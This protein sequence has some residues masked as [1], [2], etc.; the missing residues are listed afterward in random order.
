[1]KKFSKE[2]YD[3][4]SMALGNH[5]YELQK[6]AKLSKD[7][8]TPYSSRALEAGVAMLE[9][10]TDNSIDESFLF[11]DEKPKVNNRNNQVLD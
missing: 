6:E 5:L 7:K 3:S 8:K 11:P 9:T 2:E 1:M 4:I 10:K